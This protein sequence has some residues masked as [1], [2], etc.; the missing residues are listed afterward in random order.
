ME[1]THKK[2]KEHSVK[3]TSI[4]EIVFGYWLPV[5]IWMMTIFMFSSQHSVTVSPEYWLNFAFFKTLHVI[6]YMT[7]FV[8]TYRAVAASYAGMK[9]RWGIV[10]YVITVLYAISDEFHQSFTP[11]RDPT[12]RD[13]IIDSVAALI[14]WIYL[15]KLLPKAP[16]ILKNL[17]KLLDI[18]Y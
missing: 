16:K 7:L 4:T 11:T 6:I 17:A 13:V 1:K 18:P 5:V 3:T 8:L 14:I 2:Q 10:A 15:T 9:G 12:V